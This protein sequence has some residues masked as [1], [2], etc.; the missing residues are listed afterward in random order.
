MKKFLAIMLVLVM[1]LAS[2]AGCGGGAAEEEASLKPRVS[3]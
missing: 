3:R 1:V 2:F